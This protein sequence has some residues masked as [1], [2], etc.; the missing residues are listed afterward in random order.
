MS[1]IRLPEC[2]FSLSTYNH[3][4]GP[5]HAYYVLKKPLINYVAQ[6]KSPE[7]SQFEVDTV[8]DTTK[9]ENVPQKFNLVSYILVLRK[10]LP[11]VV[12]S[13]SSVFRVEV[14]H[15]II[16]YGTCVSGQHWSVSFRL[17]WVTVRSVSHHL[18][19]RIWSL[20]IS[21]L[22]SSLYSGYF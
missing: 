5:T 6:H 12:A 13:F 16:K 4:S 8:N 20:F 9:L 19:T 22:L 2:I 17:K 1:F 7:V 10:T 18:S 21:L 11:V 15:D 14:C 3:I